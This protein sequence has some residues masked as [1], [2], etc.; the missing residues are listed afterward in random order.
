[1]SAILA[2]DYE[3]EP[4]ETVTSC[5]NCGWQRFEP[6]AER[7]RYGLPVK[8][9]RCTGCGLVFISPRMVDDG[10]RR[11]Y[12]DGH[13]RTLLTKFYGK[14]IQ[15][16]TMEASQRA[17]AEALAVYLEPYLAKR[18]M[19]TVLDVGGSTGVVAGTMARRFGL[20]ATVLDPADA[21]LV[22]A[23]QAGLNALCGTIEEWS[24]NGYR[25]DLVLLCQTV[26]HL[27]DIRVALA[28]LRH[29]VSGRGLFY[30]DIACFDILLDRPK[31]P[32]QV[33]KVDHPYY[34]SRVH[35]E[36]YLD[37]AGF[38]VV[39]RCNGPLRYQVGYLCKP[40]EQKV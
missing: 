13:Y 11:F 7:D 10:Y 25:W 9:A 6:F 1:M 31:L 12:A 32:E 14:P 18:T 28:K 20:K 40:R 30:M 5:N 23:K 29:A 21:E 36:T 37:R 2:F 3:S 26:D 15:P 35:A 39:A 19:S 24:P 16:G 4:K 8:T 27:L 33:V 22:V 38:Q 17:Y 34:L